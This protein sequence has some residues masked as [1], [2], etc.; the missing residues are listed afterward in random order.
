MQGNIIYA[1]KVIL[2]ISIFT[3]YLYILIR[4]NY[5]NTEKIECIGCSLFMSFFITFFINEI[6]V[7][8]L[9][10]I[11]SNVELLFWFVNFSMATFIAKIQI[12]ITNII[13]K[14]NS[15]TKEAN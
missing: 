3:V 4:K 14:N 13:T 6:S 12:T 1:I 11:Y 5:P 10:Y 2:F 7:K 9:E 8:Y 15:Y